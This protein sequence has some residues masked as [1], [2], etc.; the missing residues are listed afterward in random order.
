[1]TVDHVTT[2]LRSCYTG[3]VH[4]AM[5][6][7]EMAPAA[8][9]PTIVLL[10]PRRSLAGPVYPLRGSPK[11][12]L[13]AHDSLL[14]WT[15]FLAAAPSGHVVVC[16]PGDHTLAHMGEL[17]AETLHRR[18]VLGYVVDGGT[19]DTDYLLE[20]GFP[21]AC[22][23]TTP[24]DIVGRWSVDAHGD[25]IVIGGVAITRGDYLLADRDGAIVVA[26]AVI[27]EVL[28]R[29]ELLMNTESDLRHSLRGG[30]DPEAAY[31]EYGVF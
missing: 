11:D 14:S 18:G 6:E 13:T 26:S 31:L 23:Y 29:A 5:R 21:V 10:D 27:D 7:L 22:C 9:P 25:P 12:G 28:A 24:V 20:L 15:Q 1:V 2:R 16:Q 17:S 19:R 8:L 4:D 30:A 3:V